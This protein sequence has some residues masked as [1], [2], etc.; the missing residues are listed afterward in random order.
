MKS[1]ERKW[2]LRHM[3]AGKAKISLRSQIRT[4]PVRRYIHIHVHALSIDSGSRL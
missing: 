3:E 4:F 2:H 1:E